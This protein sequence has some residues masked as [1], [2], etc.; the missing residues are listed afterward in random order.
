[1]GWHQYTPSS[2]ATTLESTK[3]DDWYASAV[4]GLPLHIGRLACQRS[5]CWWD[6]KQRRRYAVWVIAVVVLIFAVVLGLS[7]GKGFTI[8][9]LRVLHIELTA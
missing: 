3:S 7:L 5:N 2:N 4:G 9:W 6:S 8:S 1:M